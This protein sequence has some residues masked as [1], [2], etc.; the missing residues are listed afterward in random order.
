MQWKNSKSVKLIKELGKIIRTERKKCSDKSLTLFAYEFDLNPGNLC[1][2]ENSQIEPKITMLWR[3]SE[4]LGI[5]LSVLIN[6]LE[7]ALGKDF[8]LIDK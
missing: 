8:S 5:P 1:K 6:K 3:I 2:I 4:A 7:K